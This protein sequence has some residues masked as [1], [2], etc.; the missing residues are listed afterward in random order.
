MITQFKIFEGDFAGTKKK[1][2][3]RFGND[4]KNFLVTTPKVNKK[5]FFFKTIKKGA[6]KLLFL[7]N[8]SKENH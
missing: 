4:I 8:P 6:I 7:L 5:I 2:K 1:K 3:S